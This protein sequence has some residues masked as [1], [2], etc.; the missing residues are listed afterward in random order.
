LDYLTKQNQYE[1]SFLIHKREVDVEARTLTL[2]EARGGRL[3]FNAVLDIQA[4]Q[5]EVTEMTV[6]LRSWSGGKVQLEAPGISARPAPGSGEASPTWVISVPPGS[7]RYE[8]RLSG[9]QPMK[10]GLEV[11]MPEVR[12][13]GATRLQQWVAVAGRE[14]RT[15]EFH[16]LQAVADPP[17]ALR[18]WPAEAERVRRAGTAWEVG[19]KNWHVNLLP[20]NALGSARSVQVF[21]CDRAATVVDGRRWIH[22]ASYWLYH[23]AGRDLTLTLPDRS[24]V[25][26]AAIDDTEVTPMQPEPNRLWLPLSGAAGVHHLRLSWMFEDGAESFERPRLQALALDGV[27]EFPT[28]WTVRTPNGYQMASAFSE[29]ETSSAAA[30]ELRRA[31][32]QLQLCTLLAERM[33][34]NG[35]EALRPRLLA[36]QERFYRAC[37]RAR[38]QADMTSGL[39]RQLQELLGRNR[40]M[41]QDHGLEALRSQVEKEVRDHPAVPSPDL[42]RGRAPGELLPQPGTATYWL[43]L[44]PSSAP[45][46][47]LADLHREQTRQA[48]FASWLLAGVLLG[49]WI[50]SLSAAAAWIRFFW[51]EQMAGL[52]VLGAALFGLNWVSIFLVLLGVIGRLLVASGWLMR[53]LQR[54]KR[55]PAVEGGGL[56]AP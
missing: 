29:A 4:R 42:A 18:W 50:L 49:V 17:A 31:E 11:P 28:L 5:D 16:D 13:T 32:A 51:P 20:R 53:W 9:S 52:G 40:Q 43:T 44:L 45:Q 7:G 56:V 3:T 38:F 1:G 48:T 6:Q 55:A 8:V 35:A 41:A 23:E 25:L 47:M 21:L 46:L 54:A 15:D 34:S 39:E 33:P 22:Q 12:V 24:S 37:H 14:L 27:G 26:A 36:A 2:V 10:P 19:G 30:H